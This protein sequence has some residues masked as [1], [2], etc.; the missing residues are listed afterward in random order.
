MSGRNEARSLPRGALISKT[1]TVI[2][3]ATTPSLNASIRPLL[4][5]DVHLRNMLPLKHFSRTVLLGGPVN[6]SN[7]QIPTHW[8]DPN[9]VEIGFTLILTRFQPGEHWAI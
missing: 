7:G 6:V 1:M 9:A 2:M 5:L 3:M 4:I 8:S